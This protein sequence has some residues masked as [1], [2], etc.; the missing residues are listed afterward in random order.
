MPIIA[1]IMDSA[2]AQPI[3]KMTFG[4]M[5]RAGTA[6]VLASGKQVTA[7][8]VDIGK[9]APGKFV[10]PVSVWVAPAADTRQP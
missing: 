9:P 3:Q 8:R 5:P 6:F 1:T 7:Q 2:T 4:R 10:T